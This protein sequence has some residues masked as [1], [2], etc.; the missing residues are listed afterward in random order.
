MRII[1]IG[2]GLLGSSSAYFLAR[3]GHQ[4]TVLE[5]REG[6]GMETSFANSGMVT[7]SQADPW[8][9]P[10]TLKRLLAWAGDEK[11]PFILKPAV[12]PSLLGW[13]LAFLRNSGRARFRASLERNAALAN[14]SL[15]TFRFVRQQEELHY[16]EILRGTL[17]L[18]RDE[19]AFAKAAEVS[20]VLHA[21]GVEHEVL[22]AA[23][24]TAREPALND[25][26]ADISGGVFFPDDEAG[27]AHKFC[28]Q[29]AALAGRRGAEFRYGAEVTEIRYHGGRI[30]AVVTPGRVF[31]ADAC[32]L[33]AGSYSVCLA[34]SLGLK[35]PVRPVKGYS[36]TLDRDGWDSGPSLP[37]IDDSRH[38]AVSPLGER[39]R[40]A[41]M[42]E[43]AGYDTDVSPDRI[44]RLFK[45][46]DE[47]YPAFQSRRN[48]ATAGYWAGLRPYC[49]DGSPII[50]RAGYT[51]LYLNTG[52]GHLGWTMSA[53]SGRLLA[54][55][56]DGRETAID[57]SPYRYDRFIR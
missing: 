31:T 28:G 38:V 10:G 14:Y 42:A 51:N 46:L 11:S 44:E 1:I 49:C 45:I 54:D 12:L 52:H 30:T 53:G 13:G 39:L 48:S 37:V 56:I 35:L 36:V 8:N 17:K 55:L 18:Y 5:R 22:D 25:I 7:P 26:A 50:G 20:D 40:V 6:A 57:A 16:D 3:A 34:H 27:D 4:V 19:A 24:V 15:A 9:S 41:G 29:I 23:G 2:A 33:A 21:A 47:I 32:V 43:F